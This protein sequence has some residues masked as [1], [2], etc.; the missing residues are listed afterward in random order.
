MKLVTNLVM[1]R[2]NLL[3]LITVAFLLTGSQKSLAYLTVGESCELIRPGQYLVGAEPQIDFTN[4][5]FNIGAFAGAPYGNDGSLRAKVGFGYINFETAL[6]YKWVPIPDYEKQPAIGV[7]AEAGY[8][9]KNGTSTS[10]LRVMP[11]VSKKFETENGLF[12]PYGSL[13]LNFIFGPNGNNTGY[14]L[15]GGTEFTHPDIPNWMFSAELGANLGSS[16]TYVSGTA[17]YYF[18][19]TALKT[20]KVKT[21]R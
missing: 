15:V 21:K 17:T 4:S 1:T 20:N 10:T 11:I 2:S 5:G 7:K 19:E 12:V 13:P 16:I 18:E 9:N 6:S 8:A 3:T 14:Q